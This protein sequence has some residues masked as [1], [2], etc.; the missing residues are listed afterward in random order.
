MSSHPLLLVVSFA[1]TLLAQGCGAAAGPVS[2][3]E[4]GVAPV[5]TGES[6]AGCNVGGCSTGQYCATSVGACASVGS[7]EATPRICPTIIKVVC[8]CD[9][10]TYDNEC[11]AQRA[12]VSVDHLGSCE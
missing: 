5:A 9:G 8:G 10:A 2:E 11:I 6:I 3:G 7:C 1:L 12:G 4:E